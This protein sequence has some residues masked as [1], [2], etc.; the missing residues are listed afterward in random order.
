MVVS[1]LPDSRIHY[2]STTLLSLQQLLAAKQHDC[3]PTPSLPT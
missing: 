2:S 1:G 3:G